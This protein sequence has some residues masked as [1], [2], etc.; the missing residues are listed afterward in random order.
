MSYSQNDEEQHILR[1]TRDTFD[2]EVPGRFLDIGAYNPKLFS[3]TRR[4]FELGWSGV[5]VEASPGPFLD[6]LIEYGSCERIQLVCAAVASKRGLLKFHAN[7]AG[8]GTS[9]AAHYQ[10]WRDATKYEGTIHVGAVS[11]EDLLHQFGRDFDFINIDVEGESAEMFLNALRDHRLRPK[12]W[13]VEHDGRQEELTL[14]ALTAGYVR[15][16]LNGE[17]VIF[18]RQEG[19]DGN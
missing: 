8:T 10:K 19:H 4:L 5:M 16:H 1:I 15:E 6:L 17:N 12:C 9:N 13:C 18:A 11:L 14:A 3:N 7:E 2:R